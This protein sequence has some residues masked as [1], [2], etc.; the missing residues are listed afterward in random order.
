MKISKIKL[1]ST[2]LLTLLP[3]FFGLFVWNRL[4]EKMPIHWNMAGEID[5]YTGKATAVILMPI[6]LF[7]IHLLCLFLPKLDKKNET[8]NEKVFSLTYY[9]T[10][11]ISIIVQGFVFAT[12]LGYTANINAITS[13]I[14]GL[15]FIVIGNFM[16]KAK[17]NLTIGIKI[18]WT[19]NSE[20]N[21][22]ATHRFAGKIWFVAGFLIL[23]TAFFPE[24]ISLLL[25]F[26]ISIVA[27]L[28]PIV[29]S[30]KF[31]KKEKSEAE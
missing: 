5:G 3:M 22:N 29:Y 27:V 9:I 31:Y 11:I 4:P 10:P 24:R 30:Y 21:W 26:I 18:I 1:I 2:S 6:G 23:A 25:M 16:P 17:Q 14:L 28:I 8:Q 19:L 7:L 15:M 12:A 13:I 20:A